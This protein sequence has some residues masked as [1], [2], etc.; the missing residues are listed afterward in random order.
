MLRT[1]C[2]TGLALSALTLAAGVA[3]LLVSTA[4]AGSRGAAQPG[5]SVRGFAALP[6]FVSA[7]RF[8]H[9]ATDDPIVYPGQPGASH[10]H[11][12]VAN[13]TTNAFSTLTSL[14]AGATTCNRPADTAAYWMPTLIVD[15]VP[16]APLA[17]TIYYRRR[18]IAPVTAFPPDL[19]M[20]AG[21]ARA[22]SA[23]PLR[24]TF[25]N[26][27]A[28]IPIAPSSTP[29]VCPGGR[30]S[31]LR[32]HVNFPSCWDGS[33]LDSADHKSHMAYALADRCPPSHPVSVPGI[34]LIYRYPVAGEHT[35]ALASGGQFSG[36]ADFVNAWK[37][38][39]LAALVQ[40]CL[41]AGLR[42]GRF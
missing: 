37:Q 2:R 26:C 14:L 3:A 16:T 19:R 11:S 24:V 28:A 23:Q 20:I 15:G 13:T 39:E 33:S 29:P 7:C 6:N 27:G 10:D 8:S 1:R 40:N 21:D 5:A 38:A 36:H 31:G 30:V 17:A 41:N 42:C 4:F 12:F 22:T 9:R 25:W 32:L 35:I 34:T 18:T